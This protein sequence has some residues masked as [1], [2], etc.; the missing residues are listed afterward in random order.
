[1]P[2]SADKK[3][4]RYL[5]NDPESIADFL[6]KSLN[7]KEIEPVLKA[8]RDILVAQN[9]MALARETGMRRDKLY[10]TFGGEVDP[11][12]SR[13]LKLLWGLNIRIIA[14]PCPSKPEPVRPKLGRPKKDASRSDH[15]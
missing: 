14:E 8:L 11:T 7:K 13:V 9:V 1:M 3:E 10:G 6:N 2:V 5:R 4:L 15:S 12:L